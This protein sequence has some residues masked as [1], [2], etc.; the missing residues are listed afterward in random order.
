MELEWKFLVKKIKG[1]TKRKVK[2][3]I[4]NKDNH[5]IGFICGIK[6]YL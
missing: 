1:F 4:Q 5:K 6:D 2:M 3:N